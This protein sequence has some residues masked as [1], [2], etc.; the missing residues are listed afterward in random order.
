MRIGSSA[1][2][3]VGR[4][5]PDV[6]RQDLVEAAEDGH[7]TFV[8]PNIF[9]VDALTMLVALAPQVPGPKLAVGVV[10]APPRHPLA[11][12]QQAMTANLVMGGRLVLGVGLSHQMV[13]EGMFGL[14]FTRPAEWFREYL[15]I[16]TSVIRTGSVS[17]QGEMLS[18]QGGI[19]LPGHEPFPVMAAALGPKMLAIAGALADGTST[20]MCGVRTI[21]EHVVPAITAAAE[22][23]G[24]DR[25]PAIQ[26]AIPVCVTDDATAARAE[27]ATTF[28]LYGMLPSYRAMLD[29]EG[30][31]GP[32]D[33]AVVGTED[34]VR[35]Q[36]GEFAEAGTTEL[37]AVNFSREPE[38]RAR[39]RAV[40][41]EAA[42]G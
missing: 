11:L 32:A 42:A 29:R 27:A 33:V 17:F 30:A 6:I 15:T 20:W 34:E 7:S 22:A 9:G 31:A 12:A 36:L 39:T 3:G 25:A 10:P 1:G 14:P 2:D 21:G 8:L 18:G 26:V 19:D 23:A 35:H 5:A 24:R 16:L 4:G 28:A 38:L 40:L 37:V 41:A 13:I